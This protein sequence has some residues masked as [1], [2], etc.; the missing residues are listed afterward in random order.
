[1]NRRQ[2]G[3]RVLGLV[4]GVITALKA[5]SVQAGQWVTLKN[6]GTTPVS[7]VR[8]RPLLDHM[9]R[10]YNI[11]A[12]G[13]GSKHAPQAIYMS[14][15]LLWQFK[16]EME[17]ILEDMPPHLRFVPADGSCLFKGCRVYASDMHHRHDYVITNKTTRTMRCRYE[18]A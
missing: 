11:F 14:H 6:A 18:Q 3:L 5:Q 8:T 4:G 1:M 9:R 10:S 12:K 16:N 15:D 2:F 17:S 7:F 13:L